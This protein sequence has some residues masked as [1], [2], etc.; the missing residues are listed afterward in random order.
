MKTPIDR[1]KSAVI[2]ML[3]FFEVIDRFEEEGETQQPGG[4]KDNCK[5][6]KGFAGQK[7]NRVPKTLPPLP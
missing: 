1:I 2:I 3:D 6:T 7:P 4:K 5:H